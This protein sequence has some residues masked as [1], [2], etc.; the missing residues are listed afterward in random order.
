MKKAVKDTL[1]SIV[2]QE[3][4]NT[5]HAEVLL[6]NRL[7]ELGGQDF[8]EV[9]T[10]IP[11]LLE[12]LQIYDESVE[13]KLTTAFWNSFN[14]D[15]EPKRIGSILRP[16]DLKMSRDVIENIA[17]SIVKMYDEGILRY[18]INASGVSIVH[19]SNA[20]V[21]SATKWM[22]VDTP[23]KEY[24]M[25]VTFNQLKDIDTIKEVLGEKYLDGKTIVQNKANKVISIKHFTTTELIDIFANQKIIEKSC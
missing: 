5:F 4:N 18:V 22:E 14:L 13:N 20:L 7:S 11:M 21:C 3:I 23:V 9:A 24:S 8:A 16:K 6:K 25:E 2:G 12:F 1:E 17:D 10:D 15:K 19:E